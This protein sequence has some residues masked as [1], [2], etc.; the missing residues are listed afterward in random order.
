MYHLYVHLCTPLNE[1]HGENII[2]KVLLKIFSSHFMIV[3][4]PLI[5]LR[6][7]NFKFVSSER[8]KRLFFDL[9]KCLKE[10]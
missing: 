7:K 9:K 10:K 5:K 3:I 4:I 2:L 6:I 1:E 8:I